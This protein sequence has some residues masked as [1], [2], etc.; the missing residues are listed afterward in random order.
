MGNYV[1]HADNNPNVHAVSI[2]PQRL[3]VTKTTPVAPLGG[4]AFANPSLTA[5]AYGPWTYFFSLP[6]GGRGQGK[7]MSFFLKD[8]PKGF[9]R[10]NLP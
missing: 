6:M 10:N 9:F 3:R 5:D 4:M 8:A 2:E 1:A 7:E